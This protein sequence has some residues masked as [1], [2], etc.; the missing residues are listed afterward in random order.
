MIK[1]EQRDAI[2]ALRNYPDKFFDLCIADPPYGIGW[3]K[4]IETFNKLDR[5]SCE[6]W[7]NPKQKQYT[8]K[9]WDNER[10]EKSAFDEIFRVSKKCIIWGGNYFTDLLPPSGGWLIWDKG[11]DPN[12]TFSKAEL[13]W[14]NCKNSVD[15][16]KY[17]W[18]GFKK[19]EVVDRIHP[20]QKPVKL[21]EYCI[22]K[23]AKRGDTILDPYLGSGSSA[24]A[25]YRM[26]CAFVGYEI[27]EEYYNL[28][29]QR[30]DNERQQL[31]LF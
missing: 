17:L 19:C 28:A 10:P 5:K 26:G 12:M 31:K 22:D 20:T 23:F 24:I 18:S 2:K 3:S 13:A 30:I 25:A 4:T 7:K 16:C 21:Y 1:I 9:D 15:I 14:H 29:M 8:V 11:V 27:D 6:K